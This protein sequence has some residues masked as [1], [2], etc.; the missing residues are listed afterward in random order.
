MRGGYID[1]KSYFSSAS[2]YI[3]FYETALLKSLKAFDIR[4]LSSQKPYKPRPVISA[5]YRDILKIKEKADHNMLCPPFYLIVIGEVK[6]RTTNP[7][8]FASVRRL[9]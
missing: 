9:D 6:I 2:G 8:L 5:I 4:S 1:L 3:C 7:P